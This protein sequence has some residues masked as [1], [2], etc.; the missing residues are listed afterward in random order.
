MKQ[1]RLNLIKNA[2]AT[3]TLLTAASSYAADAPFQQITYS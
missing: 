1:N 3:L 2:I